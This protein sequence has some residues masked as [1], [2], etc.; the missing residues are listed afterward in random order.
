MTTY[1]LNKYWFRLLRT[2]RDNPK[3]IHMGL[4]HADIM[5]AAYEMNKLGLVE[6]SN[7]CWVNITQLG[8][9]YINEHRAKVQRYS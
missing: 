1:P 5:I 3:T 2:V 4:S 6:L 7:T 9:D 8:K